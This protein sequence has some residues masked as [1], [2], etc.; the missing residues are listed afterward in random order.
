MIK[1]GTLVYHKGEGEWLGDIDPARIAQV[2][3]NGE[4]GYCQIIFCQSDNEDV[5]GE[6]TLHVLPECFVPD[7][8]LL[9]Y[10]YSGFDA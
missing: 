1:P 4:H 6:N 7:R 10:V 2:F 9:P 5:V 8:D 3:A